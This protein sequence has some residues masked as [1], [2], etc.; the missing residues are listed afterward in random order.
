MKK[1]GKENTYQHYK[2]MA[3]KQHHNSKKN[4]MYSTLDDPK[5]LIPKLVSVP[6]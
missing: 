5:T 3:V 4:R 2:E 1:T 6:L